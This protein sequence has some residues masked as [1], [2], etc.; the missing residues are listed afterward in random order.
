MGWNK[1]TLTVSVSHICSLFSLGCAF[2]AFLALAMPSML[3]A[4]T[5]APLAGKIWS[6]EKKQFVEFQDLLGS[7]QD[8][9]FILLGERHGHHPHQRR[10]AFLIGALAEAG[11]YPTIVLEMLTHEQTDTVSEY[12]KRAPEYALGLA[13]ELNWADS[14]WPSWSFYDPIFDAA[15]ATKAPIVGADLNEFEQNNVLE[16]HSN[17]NE[18]SENLNYY[19]SKMKNAH[20]DLIEEDQA[21]ALAA[22]QIARDKKMAAQ[23]SNNRNMDAGSL[24]VVGASHIRKSHGIPQYLPAEE[25][26]V[27][28]LIAT[29]ETIQEFA[30]QSQNIVAGDIDDFDFLWF[31]APYDGSAFC[32]RLSTTKR[33]E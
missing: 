14:N 3:V 18:P 29:G 30:S 10:A 27:V 4:G 16:E 19:K 2:Y 28:A 17:T 1:I 32:E 31:T 6:T 5:S 7:I 33:E 21:R 11:R 9:S 13:T 20:C 25:T 15:F 26:A 24:L 22:L 8:K 12:R 23:M